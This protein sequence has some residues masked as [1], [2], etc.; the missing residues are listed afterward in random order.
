MIKSDYI[1]AF[2]DKKHIFHGASLF[3]TE[4]R[5]VLCERNGHILI[6]ERFLVDHLRKKE[7][8]V[9]A[10]NALIQRRFVSAKKDTEDNKDV[11]E[12]K[13]EFFMVDLT[14]RCNMKCKYCLRDIDSKNS[15]IDKKVLDDICNY[16]MEYCDKEKLPHISIQAW[17]GEPLLE[18][19]SILYMCNNI[20]PSITKVHFSIETN[21]TLLSEEIVKKLYDN[22]IEIGIS[23]DGDKETHDAQRVF[24]SGMGT[25]EIVAKN[26]KYA[27]SV[28]ND[29]VGSIT[30]V[31]KKNI[32]ELE[33]ILEYYATDLRLTQIKMNFVHKSGFSE[34]DDL[35]LSEEEIS[36]ASERILNKIVE[37]NERGYN[38]REYNTIVKLKNLLFREYSDI[39][40]SKGCCGGR[41]MIVFGMDGNIF[42]CELTDYS[43][44]CL[45]NIYDGISLIDMVK[46]AENT[47]SYFKKKHVDRCDDCAWYY[48]CRGGCTVRVMST[49]EN[50]PAIDKTECAVN[51]VLYPLLINLILTKPD[52]IN[53]L[54]GYTAVKL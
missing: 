16:I 38:I 28:Y 29:N 53:K 44:E 10:L 43:D 11:C 47:K 26:L 7:L 2:R 41:K 39:C 23:I 18:V 17:G 12:I 45:G 36:C 22:K 46:S 30:T 49:G 15:S 51:T 27:Q 33:R 14:N 48:Y 40:L 42:P 20:K 37:L 5:Y 25:H 13:P 3:E 52:I 24:P 54:L 21:A 4:G 50:P 31:T 8:P 6:T 32:N 9:N 1:S 35:C 34:C 19:D